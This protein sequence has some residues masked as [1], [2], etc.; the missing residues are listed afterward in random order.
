MSDN[1]YYVK[2]S[3]PLTNCGYFVRSSRQT[4]SDLEAGD[5]H[6]KMLSLEAPSEVL[7]GCD[8]L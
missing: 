6:Q 8:A 2:Y 4:L 5:I 3:D 1:R 7:N